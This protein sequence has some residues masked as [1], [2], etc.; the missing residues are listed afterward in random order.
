MAKAFRKALPQ[1]DTPLTTRDQHDN[2]RDIPGLQFAFRPE[3]AGYYHIS[4]T[5]PDTWNDEAGFGAWFSISLNDKIIARGL[6][7]SAMAGQRV[8]IHLET[9]IKINRERNVIEAKW[10]THGGGQAYI[11]GLG[12]TTLLMFPLAQVGELSGGESI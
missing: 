9:I 2:F 1:S 8:P 6:Y 3:E 10:C 11:G 5:A 7:T 12:E 4:L